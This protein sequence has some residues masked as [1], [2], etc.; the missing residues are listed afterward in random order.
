MHYALTDFSH[1]ADLEFKRKGSEERNGKGRPRKNQYGLKILVWNRL[2]HDDFEE[3]W[4]E[5]S[6]GR[7]YQHQDD[8]SDQSLCVGFDIFPQPLELTEVVAVLVSFVYIVS[9]SCH[10]TFL[11]H[12]PDPT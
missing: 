12:F 11:R 6:K 8:Y 7:R 10:L 3:V 2:V 9:V 5:H 1:Y 4:I